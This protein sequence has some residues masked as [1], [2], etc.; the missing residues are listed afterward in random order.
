MNYEELTKIIAEEDSVYAIYDDQKSNENQ[1]ENIILHSPVKHI[2]AYN[3]IELIDSI[4]EIDKLKKKGFY[5]GGYI[6][7]EAGCFLIDKKIKPKKTKASELLLNF[8]AFKSI[9]Y[10]SKSDLKKVFEN[11][12]VNKNSNLAIYNLKLNET[13]GKYQKSINKIMGYLKSGDA[14]QV[15]YTLKYKFDLEG[16]PLSLYKVLRDRQTVHYGAFLN[17]DSEKVLSISPELFVKKIGGKI[18]SKPMKGTAKRGNSTEEDKIIIN[19]LKNDPKTISE[20]VMIVD[21]IRNDLG[22][23]CNSGSVKVDNIFEIQ[24][25][26]TVHQM[27]STVKGEV[28]KDISLLNVLKGIFPCGSITGAPKIRAMEIIDELES[29]ARGV[30]TGAI[31]FIMPNNDYCFNV[32]IRTIKIEGKKCEMG[33]GSGI[34]FESEV[35]KEFDECLLKAKFLTNINDDFYIIETLKYDANE[36]FFSDLECHL[37][38]LKNSAIIFNFHYDYNITINNIMGL[39]SSLENGIYKISVNLYKDGGIKMHLNPIR[40]SFLHKKINISNVRINSSSIFQQHKTSMRHLYNSEYKAANENGFYDAI[41]LNEKDEVVEACC[42]N[43]FIKKD[44]VL[45]TPPC[46]S[47]ALDGIFRKKFMFEN[48]VIEKKIGVEDLFNA[49]EIYLTNSVRGL[50]KVSLCKQ[51]GKLECFA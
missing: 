17:F 4:R 8:Y 48:V 11:S 46:S 12:P 15:N 19:F 27:I 5:L 38:R 3:E 49:D 21:L 41:F 35:E 6:S 45:F 43:V 31:G 23:I 42:H 30:Y 24:S 47:G 14:Y 33:I 51:H 7:Y 36:G 13:E 1:S 22:R 44:G 20:N 29:E 9:E 34:V 26:E 50:V 40:D 10:I 25:Y 16:S 39:V 32:P 37:N 2:V 18:K 28:D